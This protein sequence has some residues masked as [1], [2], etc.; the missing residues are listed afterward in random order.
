[1]MNNKKTKKNLNQ[2]KMK[3]LRFPKKLNNK[4]ILMMKSLLKVMM[5]KKRKPK[6]SKKILI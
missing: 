2:N 5:F 4:K 1:M 6:R 3:T